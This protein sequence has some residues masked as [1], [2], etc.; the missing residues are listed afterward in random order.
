MIFAV[1]FAKSYHANAGGFSSVASVTVREL[2]SPERKRDWFAV[3][4][5]RI[6]RT[7]EKFSSTV[8]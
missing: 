2:I 4:K 6:C 7:I 3:Q 1:V 5:T 8:A